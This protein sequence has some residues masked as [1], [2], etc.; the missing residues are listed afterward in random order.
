MHR[1]I[2]P[3]VDF[4]MHRSIYY[5]CRVRVTRDAAAPEAKVIEGFGGAGY[6]A[7]VKIQVGRTTV[8]RA[9]TAPVADVPAMIAAMRAEIKPR[10]AAAAL[11][12]KLVDD[13]G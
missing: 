3:T 12:K 10:A 4:S 6:T 2:K 8:T 1:N 13:A 5:L 11:V 7:M 9:V